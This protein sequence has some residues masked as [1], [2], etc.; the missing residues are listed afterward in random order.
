M[1]TNPP[2]PARVRWPEED[3][4]HTKQSCRTDHGF[5]QTTMEKAALWFAAIHLT[6]FPIVTFL[7]IL[8]S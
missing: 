2:T 4:H 7:Q 5:G 6:V 3:G 8:F 1:H